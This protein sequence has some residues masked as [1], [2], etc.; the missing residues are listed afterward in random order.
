MTANLRRTWRPIVGLAVLL[1]AVLASDPVAIVDRIRSADIGLLVIGVAGLT[2]MHVVPAL[3]WRSLVAVSGG[4]RLGY[5]AALALY[6]AAQ[7]IGGVTPAN[8][9]GDLHRAAAL[10]GQGADW[11]ATVSPLLVQRATSYLALSALSLLGLTVLAGATPT[12]LP[13]VAAG[14]AVAVAVGAGAWLLLAPPDFLAVAQRRLARSLTGDAAAPTRTPRLGTAFAI[15]FGSGLAFH[16]GSILL[17]WLLIAAV[18]SS[19]AGPATLAAVTIA[20]LSLAVPV[21]P[22]GIGVQEGALAIMLAALGLPP[23]SALAGMLLA[24][25]AML[26]TTLLGIWL[27]VHGRPGRERPARRQADARLA[28]PGDG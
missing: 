26:T 17:T 25:L 11:P 21:T 8:L 12:T 27:L 16:A 28:A 24:R 10:R 6:Y 13:I 23:D 3:A 4:V 20:R 22:S 14:F 2:A 9:G 5:R 15:G 7:A 19:A 1:L 18:D